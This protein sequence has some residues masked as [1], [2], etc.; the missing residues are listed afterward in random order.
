MLREDE[1]YLRNALT[2]E[3]KVLQNKSSE[4]FG[5]EYVCLVC[6]FSRFVEKESES[7]IIRCLRCGSSM[8]KAEIVQAAS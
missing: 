1:I 8:V 3:V 5:E 7:N 6:K 2:M 4:N